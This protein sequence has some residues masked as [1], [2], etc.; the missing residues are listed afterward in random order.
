MF[1]MEPSN[2]HELAIKVAI[3]TIAIEGRLSVISSIPEIA[4]SLQFIM[5]RSD[6]EFLVQYLRWRMDQP[7]KFSV[8]DSTT[9]LLLASPP[10]HSH[11]VYPYTNDQHLVDVVG[12]YTASGLDRDGAVILIVTE[13]HRSAIKRFLKSDGHVEVL[14]ASGQLVFLDAAELMSTFMINGN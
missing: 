11:V 7:R 6:T 1:L 13:T 12:F 9:A 4:G 14:E 8:M 5:S 3:D 10:Y 2:D